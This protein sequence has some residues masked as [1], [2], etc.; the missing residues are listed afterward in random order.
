MIALL[1]RIHRTLTKPAGFSQCA[2]VRPPQESVQMIHPTPGSLKANRTLPLRPLI[3]PCPDPTAEDRIRDAHRNRALRLARQEHWEVLSALIRHADTN[4]KLTPGSMPVAEL[5]A[6]GA[7]ADVVLAVEHAL[8]DLHPEKDAPLLRGIQAL[9]YILEDHPRDHIIACIVAQAHIDI[10]W[11]W[12][13]P[14]K[15]AQLAPRNRAAFDS[16]FARATEILVPFN[17]TVKTSP[18]LAATFCALVAGTQTTSRDVADRYERLIDLNPHNPGPMRAMGNH[19]L[20]RWNGS[21]AVLE[22]EARRTAARTQAVWGAGGYTWVMFDAISC[23]DAACAQ[24][25]LDF[26]LEG[27]RDILARRKDAQTVNLL[28]AYCAKTMCDT[29]S[30]DDKSDQNRSQIAASADWIVR[31]HL[32]ELHPMIWAHAAQGFDNNLRIRSAD[33]FAAAGRAD[34]MQFL[35]LM[36]KGEIDAGKQIVFTKEGPVAQTC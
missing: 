28:A 7:R 8:F 25:D 27:L 6:Y 1:T 18:L 32:T 4:R 31:H 29:F 17:R 34:A 3:I 11:A 20:P 9:E 12:R 36:F 14:L 15:H 26:F 13:G 19:L 21:L 5:L 30:D 16:H 23:D 24:V 33:R 22:L 35:T 10:A 2:D